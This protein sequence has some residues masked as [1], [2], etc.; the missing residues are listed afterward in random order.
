MPALPDFDDILNSAKNLGKDLVEGAEDLADEASIKKGGFSG[1]GL[2][3][4]GRPTFNAVSCA[5]GSPSLWE[6]MD[7]DNDCNTEIE[8]VLGDEV[9]RFE[10]WIFWV[11]F[12]IFFFSCC[13]GMFCCSRR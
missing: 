7:F 13:G 2:K 5:G 8:V 4:L 1:A 9:Y 3:S 10:S 12:L 6:K 11:V